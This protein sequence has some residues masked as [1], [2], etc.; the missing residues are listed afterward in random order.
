M[1]RHHR[2]ESKTSP[3]RLIAA[4]KH[5]QA[6]ILRMAGADFGQ[7]AGKLGYKDASGAYRAVE[8]ALKRVPEREVK[9]YRKLNLERLN[10]MR[11]Q[12]W[13]RARE[14]D[15][16][17]MEME[18]KIQAREARYL[19]LDVPIQQI[20]TG[21][22]GGPITIRVVYEDRVVLEGVAYAPFTEPESD[23]QR[24]LPYES[25]ARRSTNNVKGEAHG[26]GG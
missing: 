20:I 21:E 3:R 24:A 7:I 14:G 13:Q 4:E 18:L 10:S 25:S 26:N 6:L 8:A 23:A 2:T 16:E 9:N 1:P 12:Y 15:L 22:H 19:G 5:R 11:L 17:A